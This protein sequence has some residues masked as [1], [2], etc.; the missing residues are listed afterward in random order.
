M[1]CACKNDLNIVILETVRLDML[2][3][4]AFSVKLVSFVSDLPL[5]DTA[6]KNLFQKN[7]Y[8]GIYWL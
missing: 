1:T 6:C 2:T 3:K 5:N 4:I 7:R 8:L